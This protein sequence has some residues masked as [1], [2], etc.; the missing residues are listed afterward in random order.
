[1]T[2][3]EMANEV[4]SQLL[5]VVET[6]QESV[7]GTLVWVTEQA[8]TILPE[9]TLRLASKLPNAAQYIDRGF[10]GAEQ[11]LRSQHDFATKIA[12]AMTPAGTAASV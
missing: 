11:W 3:T 6:V 2:P 10:E 7:V 5:S 12:D 1:M 4:Q 8:E 9:A